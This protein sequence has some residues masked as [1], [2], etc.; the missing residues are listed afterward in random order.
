MIRSERIIHSPQ[1]YNPGFGAARECKNDAVASIVYMIQDKYFDSNIDTDDILSLLAE[2]D[3]EDCM[4]TPSTFHM[5]KSYALKNHNHD[6]DT[7]TYME[8]LSGE[9]SEEY[10]KAMDDEILSLMRRY[11]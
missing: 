2:W 1:R 5:R 10:F 6:P 3:A 11:T 4:D 7:T 8:A 9:N